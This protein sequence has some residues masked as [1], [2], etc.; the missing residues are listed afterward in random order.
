MQLGIAII[1]V[2]YSNYYKCEN[3]LFYDDLIKVMPE[4]EYD[5]EYGF[6]V[7]AWTP[8]HAFFILMIPFIEYTAIRHPSDLRK[9]NDMFC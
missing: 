4:F 9:I 7:C 1:S 5:D 6:I 8:L 3:G 2:T